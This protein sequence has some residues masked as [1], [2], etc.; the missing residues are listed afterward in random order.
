MRPRQGRAASKLKR[1]SVDRVLNVKVRGRGIGSPPR[2][3]KNEVV[4]ADL[5][6]GEEVTI[7]VGKS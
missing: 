3:G 2:G 6:K 5:G 1:G 4:G 7:S